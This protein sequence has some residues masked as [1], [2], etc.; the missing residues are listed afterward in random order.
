MPWFKNVSM[1]DVMLETEVT[2]Y[3]LDTFHIKKQAQLG[4]GCSMLV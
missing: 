4:G 2:L 3:E 1:G